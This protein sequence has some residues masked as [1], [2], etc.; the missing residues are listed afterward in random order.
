MAVVSIIVPTYNESG[1]I[2]ALVDRLEKSL[3]AAGI[4]GYEI[5]VMDDDSPDRTADGVNGLKRPNVRAYNRR[6]QRPGLSASV[7]DGFALA[8]GEILGVMDA[9]LSHPPEVV[10]DLIRAVEKEGFLLAIGSR[11]VPGG[12]VADW[13]FL[14]RL[15]SR[16]ACALARFLTP[17]RDA[18]SGFFFFRRSILEGVR[19][20]PLGFKI[21]LEVFVKSRH[22]NSFKEVAFCF[23]DRV[24][25][26]SKLKIG[27]VASFFEQMAILS[28]DR[29]KGA[30]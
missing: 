29:L 9:G 11:Y 8:H 20:N 1:N 4:G 26:K 12:G 14:R 21:G 5:V 25:G 16:A 10:P 23:P 3:D 24:A 19:L 30:R 15:A 27:V 17:V 7:I 28:V 22:E 2:R 6:G 13:P 18:T